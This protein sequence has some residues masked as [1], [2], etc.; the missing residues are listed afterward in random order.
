MEIYRAVPLWQYRGPNSKPM[1]LQPTLHIINGGVQ[2]KFKYL[3][4]LQRLLTVD[5]F[6][7]VHPPLLIFWRYAQAA[8]HWIINFYI[9]VCRHAL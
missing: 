6:D 5:R 7:H 4:S 3:S 2:F 8:A 9:S 1:K